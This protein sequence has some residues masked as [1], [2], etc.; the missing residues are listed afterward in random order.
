M[1]EK[2]PPLSAPSTSQSN[3]KVYVRHCDPNLTG[4][5]LG[6]HARGS[7]YPLLRVSLSF[8]WE[9][10]WHHSSGAFGKDNQT[11]PFYEEECKYLGE[12]LLLDHDDVQGHLKD[13][14]DESYDSAPSLKLAKLLTFDDLDQNRLTVVNIDLDNDPRMGRILGYADIAISSIQSFME[15]C[16][17]D[18]FYHQ[19][20]SSSTSK[21]EQ[22]LVLVSLNGRFQ[23]QDDP[24][25]QVVRWL[26]GKGQIWRRQLQMLPSTRQRPE[27]LRVVAHIRVPEWYCSKVWKDAN[28]MS[29]VID[30]LRV[31]KKQWGLVVTEMCSASSNRRNNRAIPRL[32][33]DIYTESVF[34]EENEALLL[35]EVK[36]MNPFVS[37]GHSNDDMV[38]S[39]NI[40]RQTPLLDTVKSMATA[41]VFIP[42]SSFLSAFAAFF[43]S[44][45]VAS[46]DTNHIPSLI[47]M[48]EEATRRTQYLAPHLTYAAPTLRTDSSIVCPI[49][50]TK[51]GDEV[52]A[53]LK[54]LWMF[55]TSDH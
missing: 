24:S 10:L 16:G 21:E 23:L 27:L 20:P 18:A 11:R 42:A 6:S 25:P 52:K 48:P 37:I 38:A 29:H 5:G 46:V 26:Q 1:A 4:E 31:I 14:V 17:T 2:N 33:L 39:I 12:W 43:H 49:L 28:K 36:S 55:N 45:P 34:S 13:E 35:D 32:T 8:G 47:I 9:I 19:V 30:S 41:D 53:A 44:A 7:L 54:Q 15:E 50:S 40:H 3:L 22:H 51:C